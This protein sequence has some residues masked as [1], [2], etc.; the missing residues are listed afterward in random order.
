V[1]F[2]E[3]ARILA[4]PEAG[5]LLVPYSAS[6]NKAKIHSRV[7]NAGLQTFANYSTYIAICEF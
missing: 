1:L 6:L 4:W 5:F 7:R 2:F 3:K